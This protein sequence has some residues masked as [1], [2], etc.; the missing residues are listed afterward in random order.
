MLFQKHYSGRYRLPEEKNKNKNIVCFKRY[1]SQNYKK[2]A[3][4]NLEK[5]PKKEFLMKQSYLEPGASLGDSE[6]L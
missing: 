4:F 2:R 1:H 3:V 6:I 5:S